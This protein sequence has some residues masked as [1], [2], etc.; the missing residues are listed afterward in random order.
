MTSIATVIEMLIH[1][2]CTFGWCLALVA[3]VIKLTIHQQHLGTSD[4]PRPL[5]IQIRP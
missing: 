3:S 2:V 1:V 4:S 5:R